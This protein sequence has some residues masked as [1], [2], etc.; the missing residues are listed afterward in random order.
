MNNTWVLSDSSVMAL[1]FGMTRFPDNDTLS[2]D[3]DPATLG[4]SQTYLN[5][6]TVQKFPQVRIRDYDAIAAR[7][8]GAIE[9]T[10][11]NWKSISANGTFSKF[12]GTHTFKFGA[13]FRK[14]GLDFFSPGN[15]AGSFDFDRTSRRRTAYGGALDGNSVCL[16]PARLPVGERQRAP[17]PDH[18]LDAGQPVHLLLRRLR[19]GRLAREL[20]VHGELRPPHRARDRHAR[21]RTTT[22]PS[23]SIRR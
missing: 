20:E 23:A 12:V 22:S 16:V 8:L 4:F 13:D 15:G 1:R 6:I 5:Q 11:R 9:P 18:A 14:I 3:F 17:E 2:I 7:T 10:D 21:S 19:A